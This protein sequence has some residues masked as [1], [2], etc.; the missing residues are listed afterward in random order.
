MREQVVS[1]IEFSPQEREFFTANGYL[2]VR[3]LLAPDDVE[4][5]CRRADDIASGRIPF[6]Q[7][8]I[9]GGRTTGVIRRKPSERNKTDPSTNPVP[10]VRLTD[11]HARR[12]NQIYPLRQQSVDEAALAAA[13]ASGDPFNDVFVVNHLVDHDPVFRGFAAHP[14]IVAILR[15]LLGPNAKMFQDHIFNKGPYG[16]ANRYHQDGF[17]MFSERSVSCWIALDDVTIEN[18][19]LRYIPETAGYG[20]FSFDQL[21][22]GITARELEQEVLVPLAPGD[23]VVHDRWT[24]H[25]TGPNETPRRRRGWALH[26]ADA[27]SRWVSD[28]TL[29]YTRYTQTPD[30]LHLAD[31]EIFG[32]REYLLVCGREFPGCI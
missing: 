8:E 7:G 13:T 2:A 10:E 16:G 20:R 19:C 5:L 30:G 31:D 12:G 17:F 22:D 29:T 21:G 23:A 24:I 32:N 6:P 11:R 15:T 3:G 9:H 26:Y 28:P 1:R 4:T 25:A 14:N 18:G 27:K